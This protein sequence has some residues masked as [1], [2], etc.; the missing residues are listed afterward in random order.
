MDEEEVEEEEEEY[1]DGKQK[2]KSLHWYTASAERFNRATL[3]GGRCGR[4]T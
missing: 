3:R 2:K 1:A 4:M